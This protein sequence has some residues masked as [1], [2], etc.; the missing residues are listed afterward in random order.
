MPG[1]KTEERSSV[2]QKKSRVTTEN[3]FRP[4]FGKLNHVSCAITVLEP[5]A[6]PFRLLEAGINPLATAKAILH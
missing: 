3:R 6:K 5:A 4:K 1:P 2:G